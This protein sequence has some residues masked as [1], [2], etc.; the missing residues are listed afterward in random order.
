MQCKERCWVY[1]GTQFTVQCSRKA[2]IGDFCKWHDP[3]SIKK[4]NAKAREK[5]RVGM[6][7]EAAQRENRMR[8]WAKKEGYVLVK[9]GGKS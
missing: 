9:K 8:D 1:I 4:R 6:V 5:D 2:T 3:D 7:I